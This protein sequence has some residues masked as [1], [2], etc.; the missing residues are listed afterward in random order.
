MP[1][2]RKQLEKRLAGLTSN[3]TII[4]FIV[5]YLGAVTVEE[6]AERMSEV[7]FSF[8]RTPESVEQYI[9]PILNRQGY[10][11]EEGGRWSIIQE[12][13]P[14]HKVL[15]EVMARE[16]RLL[17]EREVRSRLATVLG[18]KVREVCVELE[19]DPRLKRFDGRWGLKKWR[20]VND[21]VYETLKEHG[22]P[23]TEKELLTRAA[24]RLNASEEGLI[25]DPRG[26]RRFLS[27]R[28]AWAL[29]EWAGQAGQTKSTAA[30]V[31][32]SQETVALEL[33]QSFLKART[34]QRD[35]VR[36]GSTAKVKLKKAA[37]QQARDLLRE[38]AVPVSPIEVD[39]AAKLSQA[40][41]GGESL[42]VTS[43]NRVES[44]MKERTLAPKD[45]EAI[46]NFIQR[47][48]EMEDKS[49]GVSVDKLRREPLSTHK[50]ISLLKL[51][52]LPYFTQRLVI[53]D[54]YYRF[55]AELTVP[56]P[57]QT[58]LNPAAQG[59]EF[60]AQVLTAVFERLE[61]AA[62]APHGKEIEVVQRDGVRY[63][64]PVEGT[65]LAKKAREDFLI[66]QTDL[67]DYFLGNNFAAMEN[68]QLLGRAARFNLWL[69]GFPGVYISTRDFLTQLPEAFGEPPNE[70]N[71]VSLRF[72]LLF[73]N[74]TFEESH[75][76]AANYLDQALA[77]LD[78][79][80]IGAFFLLKDMMRLL[81]GHD[82]MRDLQQ[83]HAFRYVFNFPQ[84]EAGKDKDVILV[85][86]QRHS[87]EEGEVPLI[88]G[89][90]KDLKAL[91]NILVDL[92]HNV[93]QGAYYEVLSQDS[94][95]RVLTK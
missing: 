89:R 9:T 29:R 78:T 58:V 60:A 54:D 73:A 87:E 36:T 23:L 48:M 86:V 88:A 19:R 44:S 75:N 51:K 34:A 22:G 27:E 57:G 52:Y 63:R 25:F 30:Q 16:R 92:A 93:R 37:Q 14:E 64:L 67:L 76:L 53:A 83:R 46:L 80:G 47:L 85:V 61:G 33:E 91:A 2:V 94:V 18:C 77:L 90:V 15:P 13:L 71:E 49:V 17:Y 66:S 4:K 74:F 10:Y 31:A 1:D 42:E 84:M 24:E 8:S 28:K 41:A 50:I 81:K 55:A 43:Y 40:Q 56:H 95:G 3:V 35:K 68:D 7:M 26:D 70:N 65:P 6:I 79:G 62:W 72:D 21:Q 20:L 12:K 39:L 32:K 59:G 82:F 11:R 45:R 38:R 5:Y 69:S